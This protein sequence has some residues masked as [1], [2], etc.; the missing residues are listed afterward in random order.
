M[1]PIVDKYDPVA[2]AQA[3]IDANLPAVDEGQ[4]RYEF[5]RFVESLEALSELLSYSDDVDEIRSFMAMVTE[6][7]DALYRADNPAGQRLYDL[8]RWHRNNT[9]SWVQTS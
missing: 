8:E 2:M 6:F 9:L 3:L 1:R 5:K 7:H 4:V